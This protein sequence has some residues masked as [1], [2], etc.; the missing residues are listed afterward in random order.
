TSGKSWLAAWGSP[1]S[2][3]DR[4]RVTSLIGGTERATRTQGQQSGKGAAL[5]PHPPL[6]TVL[7]SLPSYGSSSHL[8]H[9]FDRRPPPEGRS[10]KPVPHQQATG[11]VGVLRTDVSFPAGGST[12]V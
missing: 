5:P 11:V 8:R 9:G 2:R 3:A 1:C 6:R 4:M 7:E 12:D 10:V